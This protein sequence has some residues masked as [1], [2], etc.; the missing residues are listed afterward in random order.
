M[1]EC[2]FMQA[3][4]GDIDT[5]HFGFLHAG[6]VAPERTRR[7]AA[8][9]YYA[10]KVR[11]ASMDVIEHEI[12]ATYGAYR[13]AEDDSDYWRIANFLLPFYTQNPTL[14]IGRKTMGNA[15]VPIDDEHVMVWSFNAP[16]PDGDKPGI[17]GLQ[18]NV[19]RNNTNE[20]LAM[21]MYGASDVRGFLPD[22]TDWLGRF[23]PAQNLSNDYA[24]DREAQAAGSHLLGH[25]Q[26]RQPSGR[27]NA[28]DDG[29]DL[30]PH[31]GAPR[32]H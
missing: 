23:R 10:V 28:G 31:S 24:I 9:D 27:C 15:W 8:P 14:L 13:P 22:T 29:S 5:V 12:G 18:P 11:D 21:Q 17:G 19:R 20:R 25:P 30:R 2:N 7:R 26:R 4:E 6:H 3:L 1:R 32:H 16:T